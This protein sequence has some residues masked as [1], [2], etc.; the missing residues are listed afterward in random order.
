MYSR[1]Q[2]EKHGGD[3]EINS[4]PLKGQLILKGQ[5][6]RQLPQQINAVFLL[7]KSGWKED[8]Y[9]WASAGGVG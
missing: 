4:S 7:L 8:G 5:L 9:T 1:G 2:R 3:Y 6:S